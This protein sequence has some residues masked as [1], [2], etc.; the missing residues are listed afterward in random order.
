MRVTLALI[1]V[2]LAARVPAQTVHLV[3][4][5]HPTIQEAVD[6]AANGDTILVSKGPYLETVTVTGFSNLLLRAKGKVIISPTA[7][8]GLVLDG[9][10]DCT[11]QGFRVEGGVDGFR[12]T[13]SHDCV[14]K[15]CQT[16]GTTLHGFLRTDKMYENYVLELDWKHTAKGGNSGLFVHADALPQVGAPYPYAVEVQVMDG[17]HGSM[18]GIRVMTATPL[19]RPRGDRRAQPLEDH[20]KPAGQWNRLQATLKGKEVTLAVNGKAL[21]VARAE[22][23]Q[24]PAGGA[25]RLLPEGEMDFANLFVRELK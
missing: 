5:E 16:E 23:K 18:F 13:A 15:K 22:L 8:A 11:V 1:V 12:L 20:A 24:L 14:L 9:C 4:Q 21:S 2:V 25:F 17:D 3:P 19:T 7:G 6:A 10:S